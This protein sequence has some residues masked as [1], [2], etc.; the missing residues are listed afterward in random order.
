MKKNSRNGHNAQSSGYTNK[1][2]VGKRQ[3]RPKAGSKL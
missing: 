3:L 1:L 2:R